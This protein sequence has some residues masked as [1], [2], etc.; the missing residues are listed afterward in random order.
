MQE[1]IYCEKCGIDYKSELRDWYYATKKTPK[2]KYKYSCEPDDIRIISHFPSQVIDFIKQCD[3]W[4]SQLDVAW[5]A[6]RLEMG[7]L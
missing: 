4:E 3:F 1:E 2:E 5:D 6:R 7:R